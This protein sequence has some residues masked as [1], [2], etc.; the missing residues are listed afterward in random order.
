MSEQFNP[1]L[2]PQ[3]D[4]YDDVTMQELDPA[5]LLL[6]P[7]SGNTIAIRLPDVFIF[8]PDPPHTHH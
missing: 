6:L 1:T 7:L 2:Q 8:Y 5:Q 4:L 3:N